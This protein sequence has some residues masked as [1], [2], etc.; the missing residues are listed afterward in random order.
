MLLFWSAEYGV[1]QDV[2][3]LIDRITIQPNS[4]GS[5]RLVSIDLLVRFEDSIV[6]NSSIVTKPPSVNWITSS[7]SFSRA[8]PIKGRLPVAN[9]RTSRSCPSQK[10]VA[11]W[12]ANETSLLSAKFTG[13]SYKNGNLS[14]FTASG[15]KHKWS[16]KPV[17]MTNS[18]GKVELFTNK[19]V[20][21][22]IAC[23]SVT[24]PEIT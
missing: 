20:N 4:I 9:T 7:C 23:L 16:V 11:W 19:K 24:I 18:I 21:D 13:I 10:I 14:K 22:T 8:V 17:S 3:N 12:T 2:L 6:Y 15:G 5:I 1:E